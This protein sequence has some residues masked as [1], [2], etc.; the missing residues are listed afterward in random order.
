MPD[1]ESP[2]YNR[3][4]GPARYRRLLIVYP[5]CLRKWGQSAGKTGPLTRTLPRPRGRACQRCIIGFLYAH[6]K[7]SSRTLV[8]NAGILCT[9]GFRFERQFRGPI[10]YRDS[11]SRIRIPSRDIHS[12]DLQLFCDF[13]IK[14]HFKSWI[15]GNGNLFFVIKRKWKLQISL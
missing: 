5:I 12:R 6:V 7:W 13:S 10:R 3:R 11:P 14:I 1:I 15:I 9:S 2:L 8:H 4:R